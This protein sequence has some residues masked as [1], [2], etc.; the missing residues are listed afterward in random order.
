MD[1]KR[2]RRVCFS[3]FQQNF[4]IEK[5]TKR[6][7]IDKNFNDLQALIFL[8]FFFIYHII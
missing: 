4:V 3:L 8:V 5:K 2:I 7:C 6:I 1:S